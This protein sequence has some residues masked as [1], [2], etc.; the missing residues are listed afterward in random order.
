MR[1]LATLFTFIPNRET[2]YCM[3]LRCSN[4]GI[5]LTKV[6]KKKK[7]TNKNQQIRSSKQNVQGIQK[8]TTTTQVIS[9]TFDYSFDYS[10]CS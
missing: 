7:S 4:Q 8:M 10:D 2:I 9:L 5:L 6:N 3:L 1:S